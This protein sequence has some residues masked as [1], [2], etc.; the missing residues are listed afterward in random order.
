M[1]RRAS[2]TAYYLNRTLGYL[3]LVGRD[4]RFPGSIGVWIPVADAVRAPW[5]VT[6]LLVATYPDLAADQ[7]PFVALLTDFDVEEFEQELAV[8]EGLL[9]PPGSE[10]EVEA[11]EIATTDESSPEDLKSKT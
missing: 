9:R 10:P 4:V 11:G 7:L 8:R 6:G 5:E 1:A 2:K 3:A